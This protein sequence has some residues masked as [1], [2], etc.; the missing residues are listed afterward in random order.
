MDPSKLLNSSTIKQMHLVQTDDPAA[1]D[2]TGLRLIIVGIFLQTICHAALY[3]FGMRW[4]NHFSLPVVTEYFF[5]TL[6]GC[7]GVLAWAF[8]NFDTTFANNNPV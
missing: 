8:E 1:T 6:P 3:A 4:W 5:E 7:Y 2:T